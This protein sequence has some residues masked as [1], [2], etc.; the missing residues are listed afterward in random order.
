MSDFVSMFSAYYMHVLA[1]IA[2]VAVLRYF[3]ISNTEEFPYSDECFNCKNKSCL[4]SNAIK[5]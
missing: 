1:S 4:S 2:I 3:V 5:R